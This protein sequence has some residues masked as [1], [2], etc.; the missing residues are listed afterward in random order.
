[1]VAHFSRLATLSRLANILAPP[2]RMHFLPFG[3][4]SPDGLLNANPELIKNLNFRR[5]DAGYNNIGEWNNCIRNNDIDKSVSI[6]SYSVSYAGWNP[7]ANQRW[8]GPESILNQSCSALITSGTS[9]RAYMWI[10]T[11]CFRLKFPDS[12]N[13]H[14]HIQL[15]MSAQKLPNAKCIPGMSVTWKSNW[16]IVQGIAKQT[17]S[18]LFK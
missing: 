6:F 13:H 1:M 17:L 11:L 4:V 5:D 2:H 7:R 15:P 14:L 18:D 8:N 16:L 12:K 9:T 3:P 10:S